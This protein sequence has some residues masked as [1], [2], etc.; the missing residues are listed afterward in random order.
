MLG[1]YIAGIDLGASNVR[2]AIAD[3]DGNVEARRHFPTPEGAP[4]D[5]TIG[6]IRRTIDELARGV[7]VGAT[8]DA[9][10][11]ALPG[12]VDPD[13]GLVASV[14]NI[15]GW[16]DVPLASLLGG[17]RRTPVAMENDANAAAIGEGWLGASKGLRH[18]V[19][20]ALGTGIGG[21]VVIDGRVHRGARFLGGEVAYISMTRDQVR[22][23]GWNNNL[24]ALVGGRAVAAR[25]RNFLGPYAKP[26]ELFDAAASGRPEAVEWLAEMREHLAMAIVDLIAI[27]DPEMVVLGGG[28][29]A[30]QCEA[31]LEPVRELVHRN[32]P[33]KTP[34][35]ASSLGEDAQIMGAIKLAIDKRH[36]VPAA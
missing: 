27:L 36:Q 4:A 17:E 33:W 19:F 16:S 30:A 9:I 15:P 2:V 28:V 25:A 18:H 5:A 11:I 12:M 6:K 26:G 7:W 34:I 8:V 3:Q 22:T 21:G 31:L 10:G 29:M 13:A 23:G 1:G 35:A 20:L 14:A 32:T 24:E